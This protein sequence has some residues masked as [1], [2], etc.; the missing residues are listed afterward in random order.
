MHDD[1]SIVICNFPK[2]II[3]KK[4]KYEIYDGG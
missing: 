4:H 1:L 3:L 2:Y